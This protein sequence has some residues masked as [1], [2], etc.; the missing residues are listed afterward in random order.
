M[1]TGEERSHE[2]EGALR[3]VA[4]RD[5]HRERLTRVVRYDHVGDVK[6][7]E[8]D[9]RDLTR[10]K[11]A[12]ERDGRRERD[13]RLVPERRNGLSEH[14]SAEIALEEVRHH[15]ILGRVRRLDVVEA[16]DAAE[17]VE[18]LRD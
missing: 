8:L 3:I 1:A 15:R 2:A 12:G 11:I 14:G 9:L 6:G 17:L 4:E 13:V 18:R 5:A 7:R 16:H 10:R